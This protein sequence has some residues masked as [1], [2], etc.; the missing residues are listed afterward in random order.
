MAPPLRRDPTEEAIAEILEELLELEGIGRDDNFFEL[1]GHSLDG[2]ASG[3]AAYKSGSGSSY[4]CWPSSTTR[5]SP[6]MAV[7]VERSRARPR[8]ID[9][10][11]GGR[12]M[13]A[14]ST[15]E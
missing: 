13:L 10:R 5:A 8:R 6:S 15:G 1:G 2:R 14:S 9:V 12:A 11:R 7:V 3:G 4:R